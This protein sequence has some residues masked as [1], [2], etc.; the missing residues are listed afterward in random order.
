[1]RRRTFTTP[2]LATFALYVCILLLPSAGAQRRPPQSGEPAPSPIIGQLALSTPCCG[3]K[4]PLGG[5]P[6]SSTYASFTGQIAVATNYADTGTK[7]SVVIWDLKNQATAPVGSQ[8]DSADTPPTNSYSHA[9]WARSSIGD[10]SGL[11]LDGGGNIYVAA[12]RVY[13]TNNLGAA[14]VLPGVPGNG[15][16]YKLDANSGL[17]TRFVQTLNAPAYSSGSPNKIPNMGAGLGNITYRC[18]ADGSAGSFYVSNFETGEIYQI[19]P[20]GQIVSRW[21]HG[22]NLPTATPSRAAIPDS[23]TNGFTA[24]GR[25][26]WAVQVKHNELFYSVWAEDQGTPS[27]TAAN[28][29][30]KIGLNGAGNFTGSAQLV[31]ALPP[32]GGNYSNPVADISFNAAGDMV[33]AERS[34]NAGNN[35]SAHQSRLLEYKLVSG[36]WTPEPVTKFRIGVFSQVNA[37]GGCD[38]DYGLGGRVWATADALIYTSPVFLYGLQ[39]TAAGGG[40]AANSILIDLD[41]DVSSADK[42]FIGDV[43]IPCPQ[44]D[45]LP[46]KPTIGGPD[47]TCAPGE[48]CVKMAQGVTY[49]W[50]V[51]GGTGQVSANGGCVAVVWGSTSPKS[52]TVTATNAAGCTSTT[53]LEVKDCA[54]TTPIDPCCPPWNKDLLKDMMFYQ[55]SGSIS[56]PYTLKFQPTTALKNQMQA[57]IN[58]LHSVNPA[59][60]GITID[61]RLHDQGTANTPAPPYGPQIGPTVFTTWNTTTGGN[62]IFSHPGFFNLPTPYPMQVGT[63]YMVHTGIYLENGQKFF[64][65]KCAN[66]EI[67]FRI[68]VLSAKTKSAPVLEFSDGKRILKSVP[69][70][71][72]RQQ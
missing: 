27:A 72:T 30:W 17:P 15:D 25:R 1:M 6:T 20:A 22:L 5:I 71:G 32:I 19:S 49:S 67:Y 34:M 47:S 40:N 21:D 53:T 7:P 57:Y 18:A 36:V 13:G 60:N 46:P 10:V 62:P 38:Y 33:V 55:G 16:I 12:T 39:G 43:E 29:V 54:T 42:T 44:C 70:S 24:L 59:I 4:P 35:P 50:S 41:N 65:D 51:T 66:N 63:W 28:E 9:G 45:V 26:T 3:R 68:Q 48:Y 61:W 69:I 56:A 11:T 23:A 8:W 14:T 2:A 37:A 64:P 31:V 52:I 58:Y